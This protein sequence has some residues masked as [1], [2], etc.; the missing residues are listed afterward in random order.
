MMFFQQQV[1]PPDRMEVFRKM[2]PTWW[3]SPL[4]APNFSDLC[5]TFIATAECDPLRDEGVGYGKLLLEA[6]NMVTFKRSGLHY[7]SYGHC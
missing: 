3:I 5:D 6:G 1:F 7:F 2:N 4:R